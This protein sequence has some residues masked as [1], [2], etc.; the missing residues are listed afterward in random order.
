MSLL[1]LISDSILIALYLPTIAVVVN[2]PLVRIFATTPWALLPISVGLG[3]VVAV[4]AVPELFMPIGNTAPGPDGWT[5][6][7][8]SGGDYWPVIFLL[9]TLSYTYG[10]VA[11]VHAWYSA[12]SA[13]S[14]RKN[15]ILAIAFGTRDFV[16]GGMFLS[17]VVQAVLG[18]PI[19]PLLS[20]ISAHIGAVALMIYIVMTAYGIASAQLFDIDLRVKRGFQRGTVAAAY[21]ATFFVVSESVATILTDQIGTLVGLA[22]TGLLLFALNPIFNMAVSLS[23]RAMPGVVDSDDYRV[24]KKLQVYGEAVS[25][26]SMDGEIS[27]ASRAALN[28][29]RA[30]L[31]LS[32]EDVLAVESELVTAA[33]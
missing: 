31:E 22:T 20:V 16:W 30:R 13:V 8:N 26:A 17:G 6:F 10:F 1:H 12:E 15:G 23:D 24:F 3:G 21:V 4:L 32:E 25:Q 28:R 9:L 19:N 2:S 5:T 14:K 29:L 18:L 27:A 33:S 11:T 7:F